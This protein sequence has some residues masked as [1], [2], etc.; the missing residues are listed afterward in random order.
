[1]LD[2]DPASVVAKGRL[3]P[4]KMFLVD[5]AAGR[6]VHDDE[7]KAELAAAEP[8]GEWLHAGL[9]RFEE[10][11]ERQREIPTHE[12]LVRSLRP[13]PVARTA[14]LAEGP[15]VTA[16]QQQDDAARPAHAHAALD[17]PGGG[18]PAGSALTS[19]TPRSSSSPRRYPVSC[20]TRSASAPSSPS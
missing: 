16:V 20:S 5:T 18:G 19:A 15:A 2:L 4:G 9:V 13:A 12:A 3:Q 17:E 10:L 11:P 1:V 7:I 14:P 6:I 8:Y